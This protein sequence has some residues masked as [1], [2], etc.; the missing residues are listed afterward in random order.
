MS[1]D[2]IS[3]LN[4]VAVKLEGCATVLQDLI[5]K[6]K[7]KTKHYISVIDEASKSN[8]HAIKSKRFLIQCLQTYVQPCIVC[9]ISFLSLQVEKFSAMAR[10][11]LELGKAL[12][13]A[14]DKAANPKAKATPK[15]KVAPKV[16]PKKPAE[17]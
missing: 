1:A 3:Q 14:S 15:P 13:R 4:A 5:A 7:N 17:A 16:S 8:P 9:P 10:E 2:L 12:V 6:K 11:R